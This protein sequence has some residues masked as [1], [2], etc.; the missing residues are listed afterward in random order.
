MLVHLYSMMVIGEWWWKNRLLPLYLHPMKLNARPGGTTLGSHRKRGGDD[1]PETL[2]EEPNE[3]LVSIFETEQESEALVIQ[4]LLEAAG[5]EVLITNFDAP[6]DVLPVGGVA[7]RVREDQVEE[8][9][10]IL[11]E[12]KDKGITD[13]EAEAS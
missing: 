8:A 9:R 2:R 1:M 12:Y 10:A 13:A 11:A 4:G 3:A 5:I 7:L 6:Q